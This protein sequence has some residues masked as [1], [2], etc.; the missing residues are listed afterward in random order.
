M[1]G[2]QLGKPLSAAR[3]ASVSMPTLSGW[4][5]QPG[6]DAQRGTGACYLLP[7][8]Q[9]RTLQGQEHNV[10]AEALAPVLENFFLA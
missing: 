6:L 1:D 4:R 2:T 8:A 7:N 10:A 5:Q 3:W 9:R